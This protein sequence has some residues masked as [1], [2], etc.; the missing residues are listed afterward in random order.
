VSS[1]PL[2]F[3]YELQ[4]IQVRQQLPLKFIRQRFVTGN[5]SGIHER[6]LGLCVEGGQVRK[7]AVTVTDFQVGVV[8]EDSDNQAKAL[9]QKDINERVIFLKWDKSDVNVGESAKFAPTVTA[10]SQQSNFAVVGD[11]MLADLF[12]SPLAGKFVDFTD[13]IVKNFAQRFAKR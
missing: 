13:E 7:R 12:H 4:H 5:E 11:V 6:C 9:P 1:L 2:P 8:H 10:R 3:L